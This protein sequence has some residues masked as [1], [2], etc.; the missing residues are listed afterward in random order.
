MLLGEL[1]VSF[2]NARITQ[3]TKDTDSQVLGHGAGLDSHIVGRRARIG[4][5]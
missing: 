4:S 3:L 5:I 1:N 2:V